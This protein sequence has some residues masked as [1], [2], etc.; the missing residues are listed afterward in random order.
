MVKS[1]IPLFFFFVSIS[2]S[3]EETTARKYPRVHTLDVSQITKEGM[4]LH[5]EIFFTPGPVSDHG[6]VWSNAGF[7]T[8]SNSTKLSL[9]ARDGIGSFE[10]TASTTF[11]YGK[12]Y[13]VRAYAQS[14]GFTVYG[15][16]IEFV[17]P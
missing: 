3:E 15:E 13:S 2:C 9:G 5:G 7:P 10:G 6:F 4:A 12:T 17:A 16:I 8:V 14:S 11:E 1:F